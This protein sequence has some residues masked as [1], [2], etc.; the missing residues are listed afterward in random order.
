[1]TP[2]IRVNHILVGDRRFKTTMIYIHVVQRRP[3][4]VVSPRDF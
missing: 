1:M 2:I 4:G 3:P